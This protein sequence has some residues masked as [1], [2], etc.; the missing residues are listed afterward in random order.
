MEKGNERRDVENQE[1]RQQV[2]HLHTQLR[3]TPESELENEIKSSLCKGD[4][5]DVT[6]RQISVL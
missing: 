5:N 1:L 6:L 3:K 4:D 2:Q